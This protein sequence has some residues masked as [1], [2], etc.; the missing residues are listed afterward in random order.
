M[1]VVLF[2]VSGSDALR[3]CHSSTHDWK[4]EDLSPSHPVLGRACEHSE[5]L[6]AVVDCLKT[7]LVGAVNCCL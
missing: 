3:L 5:P 1:Q 7:C 2:A 6:Q 4:A